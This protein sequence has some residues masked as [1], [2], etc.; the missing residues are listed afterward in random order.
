MS[1]PIKLLRSAVHHKMMNCTLNNSQLLTIYVSREFYKKLHK[2][3]WE[4][5]SFINDKTFE[6]EPINSFNGI[7]LFV[8]DDPT[9]SAYRVFVE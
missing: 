2:A 7:P 4:K 6:P 8:V 5:F 3:T 1:N 9:H